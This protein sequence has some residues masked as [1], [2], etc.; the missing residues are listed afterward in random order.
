[1]L[2]A[3]RLFVAFSRNL[4][5]RVRITCYRSALEQ[6]RCPHV[7]PTYV[8]IPRRETTHPSTHP[9]TH[10]PKLTLH[11]YISAPALL[12]DLALVFPRQVKSLNMPVA[13]HRL[14]EAIIPQSTVDDE[15]HFR[16]RG[17]TAGEELELHIAKTDRLN[18]LYRTLSISLGI[19]AEKL[20]VNLQRPANDF[21]VD[22]QGK[23]TVIDGDQDLWFI[24][25]DPWGQFCG[26]HEIVCT[27]LDEPVR[28][29]GPSYCDTCLLR[30]YVCKGYVEMAPGHWEA[31]VGTCV[32]CG[33]RF[34]TPWE[35]TDSEDSDIGSEEFTE[36]ASEL[37]RAA[38]VRDTLHL[39]P[40]T[41]S[42]PPKRK[43]QSVSPGRFKNNQQATRKRV[44]GPLAPAQ[45]HCIGTEAVATTA[46]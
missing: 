13:R 41:T 29:D 30:R 9:L 33:G 22:R 7:T 42:Q 26:E 5:G 18:D 28:H 4:I 35:A 45:T 19:P 25:G 8:Q 37:A 36:I 24:M 1:M 39:H 20:A 32:P 6:Y 27:L 38:D 15:F 34:S 10:P 12:H 46:S 14:C 21:T 40:A 16:V 43:Q 11:G 44:R 23:P 31:I 17:P 3:V 2:H